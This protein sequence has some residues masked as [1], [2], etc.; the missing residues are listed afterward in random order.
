[1]KNSITHVFFF[2]FL[3]VMIDICIQFP[4]YEEI[5]PTQSI[6]LAF[7]LRVHLDCISS[8]TL[9]YIHVRLG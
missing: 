5:F 1:M 8:S 3:Q 6:K 2:F 7:V 4:R 9:P